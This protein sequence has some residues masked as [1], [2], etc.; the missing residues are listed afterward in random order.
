M[1]SNPL[2]RALDN[3][4]VMELQCE[5][6]KREAADIRTQNARLVAEVTML[7]DRLKEV[8]IDRRKWETTCSTLLG[9]LLA[10]NDTI[11]GAVKQAVKD[12]LNPTAPQKDLEV[13]V[14]EVEEVLHSVGA[15]GGPVAAPETQAPVAPPQRILAAVPRNQLGD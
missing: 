5:A 9:R 10:I 4:L 2:Q 15:N 12:G 1:E 7:R 3:Y 14:G 11:A 6:S 13:A 8:E